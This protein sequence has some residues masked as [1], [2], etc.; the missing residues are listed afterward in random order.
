MSVAA[1]LKAHLPLM[2]RYARALTGSQDRGDAYVRTVLET[3]LADGE[4]LPQGMGTRPALYRMLS[5][6]WTASHGETQ[7]REDSPAW[8]SSADHRLSLLPPAARQAFVL[9]SVEGF[10]LA[11]AALILD[12]DE[13]HV[14]ALLDSAASDIAQQV[15]TEVLIIEDEPMIALELEQIIESLGHSVC[16]IARTHSE[17]LAAYMRTGP[18]LVLADIQLAD[19]TS[20]IDAVSDMLAQSADPPPIVFIT[21]YPERLLTGDRPEPTFLI[22]KPF[23]PDMVKAIVSQALFFEGAPEAVA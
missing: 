1:S 5:T 6:I 21:A 2:R 23:L 8:E 16:G 14:R 18:G 17:A 15:S 20:G 11:E 3:L 4:A 7:A 10:D 12:T 19:G 22:T 9:V 13:D